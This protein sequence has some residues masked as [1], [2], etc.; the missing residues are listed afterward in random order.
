FAAAVCV[1]S[2]CV[3]HPDPKWGCFAN[4]VSSDAGAGPFRAGVQ[5]VD[6]ITQAPV[7]GVA[8][9]LC[10]KLDVTCAA[11][12]GPPKTSDTEGAMEF[13]VDA[14]FD[15]YVTLNHPSYAPVLYFYNPPI[16]ADRPSQ[17]VNLSSPTVMSIFAQQVG[18]QVMPDRGVIFL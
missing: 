4:T 10:R 3:P 11:P 12:L 6:A 1:D 18:A 5:V 14:G 2:F 8:G 17:V 16:V 7:A 13:E 9:Q 15:G